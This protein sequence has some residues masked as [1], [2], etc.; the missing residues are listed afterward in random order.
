MPLEGE[1]L[2][3]TETSEGPSQGIEEKVGDQPGEFTSG[4]VGTAVETEAELARGA[5][6][7]DRLPGVVTTPDDEAAGVDE[8]PADGGLAPGRET[9]LRCAIVS[10]ADPMASEDPYGVTGAGADTEP[11]TDPNQEPDRKFEADTEASVGVEVLGGADKNGVT[12]NG[13]KL[14]VGLPARGNE[15]ELQGDTNEGVEI[16]RG[17]GPPA[18]DGGLVSGVGT[19]DPVGE[20]GPETGLEPAPSVEPA[21]GGRLTEEVR[22]PPELVMV[23]ARV[24]VTTDGAVVEAEPAADGDRVAGT[25]PPPT[26]MIGGASTEAELPSDADGTARVDALIVAMLG[27]PA[28][29]LRRVL[30]T[31]TTEGVKAVADVAVERADG[32][33]DDGTPVDDV[34]GQGSSTVAVTPSTTVWTAQSCPDGRADMVEEAGAEAVR[35][36]DRER[37]EA[38]VVSIAVKPDSE[39]PRAM[40]SGLAA[41]GPGMEDS[42]LGSS[43]VPRLKSS[44]GLD[45]SVPRK[46]SPG[47]SLSRSRAS[48]GR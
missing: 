32:A 4:S 24:I 16:P 22:P 27:M 46:P 31:V 45:A 47:L 19:G 10:V 48:S 18:V 12:V 40:L 7:G 42:I 14:A 9:L 1:R 37:C 23:P 34:R 6:Y 33:V 35:R 26:V 29:W 15:P 39:G 2:E 30:V 11:V 36:D 8:V 21:P 38:Q 41:D 43:G 25:D 20:A 3:A 44:A 17:D 28:G 5:G 13:T